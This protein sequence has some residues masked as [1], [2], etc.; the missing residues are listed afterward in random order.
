MEIMTAPHSTVSPAD[1]PPKNKLNLTQVTA[2]ALAAVTAALLGSQ[3]GAAGTVI[4]AAG[5][6]VVSTVGTAVYHASL[7]R[8]RQRVRS[9]AQRT[10]SST[11]RAGPT[12]ES[13]HS[14]AMTAPL[15]AEPPPDSTDGGAPRELARRF[16]TLRWGAAV[17]AA[18]GA[19]VLAMM[20]I[21]GFEWASGE[22]LGGNGK[23]TTLGRVVDAPAGR[24]E[25]DPATRRAPSSSEP[26]SETPSQTTE[27]PETATTTTPP[28]DGA[29]DEQSP[30]ETSDQPT[31]S[32]VSPTSPLFPDLPG[33]GD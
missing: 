24:D 11:S 2:A 31:P 14:A 3:L 28:E 16:A 15:G 21:T 32:E 8:S 12:T 17:V 20:L 22:S 13:S 1:T 10:R 7:E 5:A 26:G 6:S 4:G 23:G 18:L 27:A 33:D 30:P 9:L 19:F 29:S 25:P